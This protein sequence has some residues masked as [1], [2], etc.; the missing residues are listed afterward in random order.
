MF[1]VYRKNQPFPQHD[2]GRS[3]HIQ[4]HIDA[5]TTSRADLCPALKREDAPEL[6]GGAFFPPATNQ[7]PY[8]LA[9]TYRFKVNTKCEK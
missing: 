2:I 5:A 6:N 7:R 4:Q 9:A 3:R 8:V 1:V